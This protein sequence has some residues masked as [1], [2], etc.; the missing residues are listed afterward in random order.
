MILDIS[1]SVKFRAFGIT[2]GNY[3]DHKVIPVP[4]LPMQPHILYSYNDHG[5]VVKVELKP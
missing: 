2:F 5:V 3:S 1:W 4:T